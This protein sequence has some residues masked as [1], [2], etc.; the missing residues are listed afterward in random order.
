MILLPGVTPSQRLLRSIS[1][2]V[3]VG[4]T[5]YTNITCSDRRNGPVTA[6]WPALTRGSRAGQARRTTKMPPTGRSEAAKRTR[7]A[8]YQPHGPL[9]SSA[10]DGLRDTKPG[11]FNEWDVERNDPGR[12]GGNHCKTGRDKRWRADRQLE[13]IRCARDFAASDHERGQR[14]RCR[15]R[16]VLL[17]NRGDTCAGQLWGER[18]TARSRDQSKHRFDLW[19]SIGCGFE[20]DHADGN[21]CRRDR[22]TLITPRCAR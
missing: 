21:E 11:H 5:T 8:E 17:S 9:C 14:H 22:A 1:A 13:Y 16:P 4:G 7:S 20:H 6:A 19:H 3:T 12:T 2:S 15:R 18:F 10:G